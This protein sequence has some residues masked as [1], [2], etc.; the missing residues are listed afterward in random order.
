[1]L[2]ALKL[3][4]SSMCCSS[5]PGVQTRMFMPADADATPVGPTACKKQDGRAGRMNLRHARQRGGYAGYKTSRTSVC[6]TCEAAASWLPNAV[7]TRYST[8]G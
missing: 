4:V 5:R 3:G 6:L 8:A 2:V 1:M 7:N